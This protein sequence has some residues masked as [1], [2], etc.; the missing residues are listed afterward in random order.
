LKEFL[1]P[2]QELSVKTSTLF[3]FFN[4]CHAGSAAKNAVMLA[5]MLLEP[6][7]Q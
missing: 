6:Q 7:A 5:K 4:N 3:V 1:P 2:I